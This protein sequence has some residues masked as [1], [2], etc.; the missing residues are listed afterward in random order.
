MDPAQWIASFSVTHEQAKRG[1]LSEGELKKYLGMRDELARSLMSAQGREVPS[2]VPP[3]RAF[4]VAHVFPIE[5]NNTTRTF[6]SE[7]SCTGFT[8]LVSGSF[9]EGERVE[10]ALTPARGQ[11]PIVG[12]S[13]VVSSPRQ[14]QTT[15]RLTCRIEGLDEARLERLELALFD[16]ALSRFG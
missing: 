2:G 3:R 13:V 9:K 15:T 1:T 11:E 5:I 16:A 7:V 12:T 10:W 14:S 8:A 4:R 6:T